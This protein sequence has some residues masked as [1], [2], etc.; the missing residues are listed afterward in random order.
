MCNNWLRRSSRD[1][2]FEK[3]TSTLASAVE[4]GV[5]HVN[6]AG[7]DP[8]LYKNIISALGYAHQ[9]GVETALITSGVPIDQQFAIKLIE[10][11]LVHIRFSLDAPKAGIH[12]AIRGTTN[13][14]AATLSS[15]RV[16]LDT[17]EIIGRRTP[18]TTI[19]MTIMQNNFDLCKEMAAFSRE[20][21]VNALTFSLVVRTPNEIVELT[22][23]K[24]G[25]KVASRQFQP[26][27]Q[28]NILLTT[29][30]I[31]GLRKD[32]DEISRE[33]SL[34]T[35]AN[36]VL[37]ILRNVE[38]ALAGKYLRG[39]YESGELKCPYVFSRLVIDADGNTYPCSPL[40]FVLGNIYHES[41]KEIWLGKLRQSFVGQFNNGVLPEICYA[42]C[43]V[44]PRGVGARASSV[45]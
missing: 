9:N 18:S 22:D 28:D 21:G 23:R 25:Q 13:A 8:L 24:F 14:F 11:G 26:K 17:Q 45:S 41:L 10:S 7:G 38:D 35:N 33:E 20:L 29:K 12:N 36:G 31:E 3:Y 2:S 6:F 30:Q 15:I 43:S 32:M 40:R 34:S 44:K 37:I 39:N 19:N 27:E 16:L 5:E 4:L 42:C 1:L